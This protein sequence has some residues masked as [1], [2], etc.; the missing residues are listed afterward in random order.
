MSKAKIFLVGKGKS[1]KAVLLLCQTLKESGSKYLEITENKN[2][3]NMQVDISEIDSKT[4]ILEEAKFIIN[5]AIDVNRYE[6]KRKR[7]IK[8]EAKKLLFSTRK[9]V[10]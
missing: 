9:K 4:D 10:N 1:Q 8:K 3:A 7:I 5:S 2:E 6:K